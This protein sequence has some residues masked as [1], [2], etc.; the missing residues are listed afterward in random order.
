MVNQPIQFQ[1]HVPAYMFNICSTAA[2]SLPVGKQA[3]P[4]QFNV[5]SAACNTKKKKT[6][7][8][9]SSFVYKYQLV[10]F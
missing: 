7:M 8:I 2:G 10:Q 5:Y 6:S 1:K 3:L 9:F 4:P